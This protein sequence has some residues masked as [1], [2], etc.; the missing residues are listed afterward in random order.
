MFREAL[1]GAKGL[2]Q[3][4][5]ESFV[6]KVTRCTENIQLSL[7]EV[8]QQLQV[9][10]SINVFLSCRAI[11]SLKRPTRNCVIEQHQIAVSYDFV[12]IETQE[13]ALIGGK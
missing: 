11:L 5:M 7:M 3:L 2:V 8:Y 10:F 6:F 4:S 13:S 1:L 12:R 9:H